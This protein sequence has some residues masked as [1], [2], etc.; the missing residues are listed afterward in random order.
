MVVAANKAGSAKQRSDYD[1]AVPLYYVGLGG[2]VGGGV[3]AV[4]GA[5]LFALPHSRRESGMQATVA[6][7]PGGGV[8]GIDGTF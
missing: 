1:A 4:V 6:P 7:A 2:V 8:V 3:A 5:L